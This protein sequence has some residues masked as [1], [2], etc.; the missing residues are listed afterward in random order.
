MTVRVQS[1]DGKYLGDDIG[2]ALVS[3]R[4]ARTGRVLAEGVTRGDNG[5]L[6]TRYREGASLATIVADGQEPTLLWLAPGP[7]TASFHA[8]LAL[9]E[10]TVLEVSAHGPL[11]GLQSA[12]R[13]ST[14]VAVVPGQEID[15][16]VLLVPGL[17]VQ[18]MSPATHAAVS[19]PSATI[20][21]SAN[22]TLMCGCPITTRPIAPAEVPLWPPSDFEVHAL[23]CRVGDAS[24]VTVPLLYVEGSTSLFQAEYTVDAP[25][26]YAATIVAYQPRTRN[27]GMGKVTWFMR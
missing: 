2:G 19:R 11:G 15:G 20:T 23:I 4:N 9:D 1:V 22:V 26:D 16:L 7:K 14:E 25:G 18:V 17:L 6:I 13:V 5:E 3:I 12:V 27:A 21:L 8:S 10:P 24:P